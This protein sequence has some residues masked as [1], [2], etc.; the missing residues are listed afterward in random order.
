M[1]IY[2]EQEK[3]KL[4]VLDIKAHLQ[5]DI[6]DYIRFNTAEMNM[7]LEELK[8]SFEDEIEALDGMQCLFSKF[9]F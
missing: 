9:I 1:K 5:K 4:E 6:D 3:T 2:N 7:A 8:K